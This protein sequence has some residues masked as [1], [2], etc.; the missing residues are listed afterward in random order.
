MLA[1]IPSPSH[2]ILHIGPLALHAYGLMLAIGVLVAAKIADVR[3][4]RTGNDP[5]VISEIAVPVVVAGVV[6]ARVYHL[7]TGYKWS[8]GGIVGA[9][10]IW[11]GGLSIWG[12]V[13]GGLIAVV[14]LARRK[15]LDTLAL[16]DAVGPGVVVAQAIGRW[17]NYFNQELFGRP[18]K[19]PWALEIDLAHR[20]LH[21]E[22]F[23]TFQPT[24]LYE[25]VWCL[26]IFATIV[27]I[28]QHRGLRKGQAF[29][30]YVA[31]YC[32]GRC[33][34]EW[35]RV[36][37]ASRIFGIRFNLLLSAVIC[38]IGTISFVRLGRRPEPSP[39]ASGPIPG[40]VPTADQGSSG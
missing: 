35:L 31:M 4:R 18:S 33:F 25:S 6:G 32:F 23:A 1:Y 8:T 40:E 21:Y 7:F 9:F 17:G 28:E 20:P 12:A 30:L 26:I 3:W 22:R 19:L 27:W 39:I 38:V 15:H 10:E 2:G 16:L 34:F 14:F 13:G 29:T 37:P 5:K 36:D 24:F 11:N